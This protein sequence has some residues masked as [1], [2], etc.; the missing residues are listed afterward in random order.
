MTPDRHLE[1]GDAWGRLVWDRE[2]VAGGIRTEWL[3]F[4]SRRDVGP[5]ATESDRDLRPTNP[6][7]SPGQTQSTGDRAAHDQHG[8]YLA[9]GVPRSDA[10]GTSSEAW[11]SELGCGSELDSRTQKL[12]TLALF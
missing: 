2:R 7:I 9:G 11:R 5:P 12:R 10:D 6:Q 4:W 8:T 1:H 3:L